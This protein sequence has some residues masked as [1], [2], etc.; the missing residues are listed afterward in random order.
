M[1]EVATEAT[2]E[3]MNTCIMTDLFEEF[4]LEYVYYLSPKVYWERIRDYLGSH[5]VPK[6]TWT[7]WVAGEVD[8]SCTRAIGSSKD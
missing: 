1:L 7:S 2:I 6:K 4:R 3:G 5:Y 8:A